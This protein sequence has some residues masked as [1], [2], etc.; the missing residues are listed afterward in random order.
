MAT[1]CRSADE[2]L[3]LCRDDR[4]ISGAA[5]LIGGL[6]AL[7]LRAEQ[8]FPIERGHP[9]GALL[10]DY[11][12]V[13]LN[14]FPNLLLS[15]L[16]GACAALLVRAAGGG[17]IPLRADG[18]W[19]ALSLVLFILA[20]DVFAYWVHRAQ[21]RIPALWAM[22]SLH[23]SAEAVTLVTG[24]RHFWLEQMTLA[25]FFPVVAILFKTPPAVITA[26]SFLY[27]AFDNC[28]HLNV[29]IPL[30]KLAIIVNNPQFHRI[31][32][33]IESEHNNKNFCKML[34]IVD[35]V[36]GTLWVPGKDEFP[37]TGLVSGEKPQGFIDGA[38]WPA[39]RR[40][41]PRITIT[42]FD[43]AAGAPEPIRS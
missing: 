9:R 17:L 34:P 27:F 20:N 25:A 6:V 18:W 37:P 31:H 24:A 5:L 33:S 23:H 16:T 26:A 41:Q 38:L 43:P 42:Q 35:F 22:H 21:H 19:F 2:L 10:L 4:R 40:R 28:A 11:K 1:A 3:D 8:G 36:F 32:H 13:S 29:R 15:P 39:R 7:L 30:G 12:L 14:V